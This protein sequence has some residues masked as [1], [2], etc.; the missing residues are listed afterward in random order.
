MAVH[1]RSSQKYSEEYPDEYVLNCYDD[2][3]KH[4]TASITVNGGIFR[5][6]NPQ[7][8]RAEGE[9]TDFCSDKCIV[10]SEEKDGITTYTV[11]PVTA[12]NA[13]AQV[14]GDYF[15]S[16]DSAFLL[17]LRKE[18]LFSCCGIP[19]IIIGLM[20]QKDV[21]LD[22]GGYTLTSET[23][24]SFVVYP[25]KSFTI[26]NGTIRN[27]IGTVVFVLKGSTITLD[28]N[29]TLEC[30]DGVSGTNNTDEEGGATFNIYGD[31]QSTDI[32]VWIQGPKNT[33]NIDGADLSANYFAVYQNGSFG[34]NTYTIRN[35]TIF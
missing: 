25:S 35:S 2:N 8:C 5:G 28:E 16:L 15:A 24:H 23:S 13:V 11:A 3:Y 12:E 1:S 32:A 27:T 7:D 10:T 26:Q 29:A 30:K 34:G 14:E 18:A 33:V 22:L 20:S 4:K 19:L 31:I 21:I 6:F 17:P 9:G